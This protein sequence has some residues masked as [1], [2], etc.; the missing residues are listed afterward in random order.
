MVGPGEECVGILATSVS[1]VSF[2]FPAPAPFIVSS[3]FPA[4]APFICVPPFLS[5][6]AL[7][8][9]L[10]GAGGREEGGSDCLGDPFSWVLRRF[11]TLITSCIEFEDEC[12]EP[13]FKDVSSR[14]WSGDLNELDDPLEEDTE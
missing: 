3:L 11:E 5:V 6:S 14:F 13:E 7:F 10:F 8:I 1:A 9:I 12:L 2:L 4:P